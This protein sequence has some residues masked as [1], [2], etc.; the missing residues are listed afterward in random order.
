MSP[1]LIQQFIAAG[2]I[3]AIVTGIFQL[4]LRL[5]ENRNARQLAEEEQAQA[6]SDRAEAEEENDRR[7]DVAAYERLRAQLSEHLRWDYMIMERI[8]QDEREINE[9][10][11]AAGRPPIQF[12]P[13][14][15][16][17]RFYPLPRILSSP[18]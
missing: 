5:V 7:S 17:P 13:I 16:P 18:G 15:D 11:V 9:L 1:P 14:P 12:D 4:V 10:R 6:A 2:V 8:R 3:S